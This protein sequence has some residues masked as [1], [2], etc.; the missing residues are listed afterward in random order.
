[1]STG[2]TLGNL[3]FGVLFESFKSNVVNMQSLGRG[4]G[5]SDMKDKYVVFD[6]IDCFDKKIL[7][8]KIYLQGLAKTKIYDKNEY[9]YKI[10]NVKI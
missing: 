1:M 10:I 3:C 6:I 8:N 2:I 7:S 5:I 9:P 4:L